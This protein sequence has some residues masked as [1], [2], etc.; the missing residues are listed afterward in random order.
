MDTLV[1]EFNLETIEVDQ[2][3]GTVRIQFDQEQTPASMAVIATLADVMD[4]DPVDLEPLHATVDPDALNS[5]V[6]DRHE[7]DG[8]TNVSFTHE[9]HVI[10]VSNDGVITISHGHESSAK[11]YG[12]DAG[13]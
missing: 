8:A 4:A 5:L 13:R 10:T 2:S 1:S 3:S 7:T 11:H 12:R 9:G 6:G